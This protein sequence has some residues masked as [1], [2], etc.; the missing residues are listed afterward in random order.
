MG[1]VAWIQKILNKNG[2]AGFSNFLTPKM[3]GGMTGFRKKWRLTFLRSM[4]ATCR[5]AH[6]AAKKVKA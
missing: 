2:I 6:Q 4:L 5:A 1:G 3:V